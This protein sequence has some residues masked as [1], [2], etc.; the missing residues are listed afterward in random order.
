MDQT[1]TAYA[2]KAHLKSGKIIEVNCI[3]DGVEF[4]FYFFAKEDK[5]QISV[6]LDAIEYLEYSV[7]RGVQL[8]KRREEEEL[9]QKGCAR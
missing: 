6:L 5:S 4:P 3:Y 2:V 7:E 1:V 9:K 8:E